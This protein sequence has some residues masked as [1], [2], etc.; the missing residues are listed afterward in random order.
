M[1]NSIGFY[2]IMGVKK[3][4]HIRT[5]QRARKRLA[6]I[7]NT[8]Y[9]EDSD[10][11]RIIQTVYEVLSNKDNRS[12]YDECGRA[13][14]EHI[15]ASASAQDSGTALPT[16]PP[17]DADDDAQMLPVEGSAPALTTGPAQPTGSALPA[18]PA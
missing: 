17:S 7:C 5:I 6:G 16:G 1:M 9:G 13:L 2:E 15:F 3:T 18:G 12:L 4:A 10:R 8:E 14:F 11:Y